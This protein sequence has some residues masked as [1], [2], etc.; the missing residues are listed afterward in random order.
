MQTRAF[1]AKIRC[2]V[3]AVEDKPVCPV[4]ECLRQLIGNVLPLLAG[5][6]PAL[7]TLRRVNPVGAAVTDHASTLVLDRIDRP[8]AV[9]AF[10]AHLA[11]LWVC[12]TI[13][14]YDSKL[15]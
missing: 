10:S 5:E 11:P 7:R 9:P 14:L 8:L 13:T 1:R 4:G 12:M 6:I 2:Q 15:I 3:L